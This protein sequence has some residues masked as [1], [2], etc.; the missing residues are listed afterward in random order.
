VESPGGHSD[1]L[2]E[3]TATILVCDDEAVM[4]AL[5]RAALEEDG[6]SIAEARDGDES[7][8][9]IRRLRPDLVI[10]DMMMPGRTGL[11]VLNELRGDSELSGTPVLMLTAKAQA[12]DRVAAERAGADR[13]L[14]KPFRLAEL[15]AAVAE[16][17]GRVR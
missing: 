17:T 15:A 12:D 11:D 6:Y 5:V 13:Y 2:P 14:S 10:L 8:D 7:L 3:T 9:L 1:P 4:R 16:L